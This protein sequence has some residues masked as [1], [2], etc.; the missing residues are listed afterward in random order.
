MAWR[1]RKAL[2]GGGGGMSHICFERKW[3]RAAQLSA[4]RKKIWQ[5]KK[6]TMFGGI[7]QGKERRR[8]RIALRFSFRLAF[9]HRCRTFS[10]GHIIMFRGCT[11]LPLFDKHSYVSYLLSH[12]APA[13]FICFLLYLVASLTVP[14]RLCVFS[15]LLAHFCTHHLPAR[16][17]AV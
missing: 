6:T 16:F 17:L 10:R 14:H 12:R 4:E 3:R 2:A 9:A 1:W 13:R 15:R 8:R 7:A 11:Y 5:K